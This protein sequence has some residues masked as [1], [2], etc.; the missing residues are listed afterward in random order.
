MRLSFLIKK[1]H[2]IFGS[3]FLLIF[4]SDI[5]AILGGMIVASTQLDVSFIEFSGRIKETVALKH[6]IIGLAKAPIFGCVIAMIGCFRGF[7]I[8]NNTESVGTYTT[9]SVVNAIFW[10][11]A[12]DAIV[13]VI[14]TELGL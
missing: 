8:S 14:L 5:I 9:I 11:I 7:Q 6:F 1:R 3:S 4:F 12:I 2:S 13:S 10:V